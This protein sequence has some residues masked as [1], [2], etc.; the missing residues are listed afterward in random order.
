M[1]YRK[2]L[3]LVSFPKEHHLLLSEEEILLAREWKPSIDH[4]SNTT[5]MFLSNGKT[6]KTRAEISSLLIDVHIS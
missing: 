6:E 3:D 5:G 1:S 4:W 2:G